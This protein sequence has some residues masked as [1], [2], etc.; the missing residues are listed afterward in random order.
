MLIFTVRNP[1]KSSIYKLSSFDGGEEPELLIEEAAAISLLDLQDDEVLYLSRSADQV[2]VTR[3][4]KLSDPRTSKADR[5]KLD[6]SVME[7]IVHCDVEQVFYDTFD[8]LQMTNGD[9]KLTGKIH[10][11]LYKPK[12]PLPT[13]Q[14][15][16]LVESFYGGSNEYK[17][18]IHFL[19]AAGLY[20]LSPSPRG[21]SV[22][23]AEFEKAQ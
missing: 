23:S 14:S 13:G 10:A 22:I 6:D 5:A 12:K 18:S 16:A 7:K 20:V 17:K 2:M 8:D 11:F 3:S 15:L 19:C 4:F 9:Q 21:G 1:D